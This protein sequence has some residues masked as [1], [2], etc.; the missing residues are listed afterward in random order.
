VRVLLE[1]LLLLMNPPPF[2]AE[3][4]TAFDYPAGGVYGATA[5]NSPQSPEA[6]GGASGVSSKSLTP[7]KIAGVLVELILLLCESASRFEY[8]RWDSLFLDLAR[9]RQL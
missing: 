8:V 7:A 6:G 5:M 9:V 2:A 4:N 3:Y 1:S